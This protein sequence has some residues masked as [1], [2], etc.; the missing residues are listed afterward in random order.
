MPSKDLLKRIILENLQFIKALSL[1]MVPREGLVLPEGVRKVVVLYGLRRSGKTY[2]LYSLF[3]EAPDASLYVD[4][5]DDRLAG[6]SPA[7]FENLR[8]AFY[9]L[10]PEV[11]GR[12][13][14]LLLDEVQRVE[15]WEAFARRMVERG[16]ARV[17]V[18]GSSSK[19]GP[20]EIKS[21][22]R[23]R[24]WTV[25]VMPFSFREVL[26]ARGMK[27]SQDLV[28][29]LDRV[30]VVHLLEEYLSWGGF[31]EVVLAPPEQRRKIVREYLDA[32]F[33]KDLVERY[34]T[35]N[36]SLLKSL[37]E[38]LFSSFASKFS[39]SSFFRKMK[40]RFPFSKD[41]LFR[42]YDHFLDAMLIF[43]VRKFTPSPY[44]RLRNPPKVYVA[45][46]ALT[47]R[48]GTRDRGRLLEN[49]IYL[50][51]RRRRYEVH[52]FSGRGECDFVALREGEM[53]LYQVSLDLGENLPREMGGLLEAAAELGLK[54]G[55]ILTL[56]EE[57]T[58]EEK[59]VE[60]TV[61]P[62]WKWLLTPLTDG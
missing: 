31:P 56:E 10:K 42:Y 15:G 53:E 6:F 9:E 36:L 22:L 2:M 47:I 28:Y 1:Q 46:N 45:D 51:L 5:E 62:A 55:T 3:K 11:V 39:L 37:R 14:W 7:D 4:F 50:E 52:Y 13:P 23:G 19:L 25:E 38:A 57:R 17:A 54:R 49:L 8:E 35:T 20:S 61:V 34:G 18:T 58:V 60:I 44:Q 27:P 59:G 48:M 40:G 30:K 16:E 41:T 26:R 12:S 32:L 24:D 21:V 29:G 33:F 43:E